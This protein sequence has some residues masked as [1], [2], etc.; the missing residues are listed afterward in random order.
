MG[1]DLIG[2]VCDLAL[3]F[4]VDLTVGRRDWIDEE[5]AG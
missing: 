2:L 3:P 4:Y 1:D 5:T